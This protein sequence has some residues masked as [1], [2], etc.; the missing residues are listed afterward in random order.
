[1][2][3][4]RVDTGSLRNN[5]DRLFRL[6]NR[7]SGIYGNIERLKNTL[8]WDVMGEQQLNTKLLNLLTQTDKISLLIK[9][10]GNTLLNIEIE[11][12]GAQQELSG[13]VGELPVSV[14]GGD[15]AA[16]I[17]SVITSVLGTIFPGLG[18][19]FQPFSGQIGTWFENEISSNINGDAKFDTLN[20]KIIKENEI[21]FDKSNIKYKG[22]LGV[23]GYIAK[24]EVSGNIGLLSGDASISAGEGKA[25][26]YAECALFD[27]GR[28]DPN[29][30][31]GAE[32]QVTGLKGEAG[33][34]F[35]NED[36]N[37]HT[38][39]EGYVGVARAEAEGKLGLDGVS[40]KA[41]AGAAVVAGEVKGGFTVFGINFDVT[42]EG[43]ALS[44]GAGAGFEADEDSIE[45]EGKLSALLGLGLKLKIS[46]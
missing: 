17:G 35:G 45:L 3:S 20:G 5:A 42:A 33:G 39:A 46:W 23:E 19:V 18:P 10:T 38:E 15:S 36:Y 2:A 25:V 32:A 21:V 37:L 16:N 8:D 24:G 14:G 11:Y 22:E 6:N 13:S 29:L 31:L 9:E 7:V 44:I 30:A 4:L 27:E 12:T 28:F 1:M 34:Q 41:E 26:G 43:E 40:L